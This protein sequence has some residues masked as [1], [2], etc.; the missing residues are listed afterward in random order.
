MSFLLDKLELGYAYFG[1]SSPMVALY[2][3]SYHFFKST[4][5]WALK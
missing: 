5:V 3:N 2:N 1:P 4:R